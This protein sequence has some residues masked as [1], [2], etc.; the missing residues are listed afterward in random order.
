MTRNNG[1]SRHDRRDQVGM[2]LATGLGWFSIAL[3]AIELLASRSITR[4]LGMRGD[5]NLIRLYG[6]RELA[7]GVG[8][9]TSEDPAPW[10]WAR[11][12]G[13]ALDLGTLGIHFNDENRKKDQ[14]GIALANVAM[15]TALDV[16]CAQRLGKKS[17]EQPMLHD[18][19]N[20]SGLPRPPAE[21]RG[22]AR[23][24]DMPRD[25]TQPLQPRDHRDFDQKY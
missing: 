14:V 10:L 11:V 15:V 5:E 3:G 7:T 1:N 25:M 20:R 9:L 6:V 12:G 21:M 16:Y 19:S 13:D 22:A 24:F 23:D 8:I 2:R 17:K 18:Y 4:A